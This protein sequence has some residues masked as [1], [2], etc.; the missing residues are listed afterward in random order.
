LKRIAAGEENGTESWQEQKGEEKCVCAR[1][2]SG[3]AEGGSR[4]AKLGEGY[5]TGDKNNGEFVGNPDISNERSILLLHGW[6]KSRY[7]WISL[8]RFAR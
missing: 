4:S 3:I 6:E 5:R 8:W 2:Q 7:A 1:R